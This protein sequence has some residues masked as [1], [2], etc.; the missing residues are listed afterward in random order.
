M[1][2]DWFSVQSKFRDVIIKLVCLGDQSPVF[3]FKLLKYGGNVYGFKEKKSSIISLGKD[4]AEL[5]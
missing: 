3:F 4:A 5:K 2:S 1:N